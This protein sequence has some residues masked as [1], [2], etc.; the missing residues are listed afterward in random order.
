MFFSF[1]QA[2]NALTKVAIT[3]ECAAE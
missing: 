2:A 1:S 3:M